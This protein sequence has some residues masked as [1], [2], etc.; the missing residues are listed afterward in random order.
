[1]CRTYGSGVFSS[2][3][4]SLF[5]LR[6]SCP[7]TLTHFSHAG[8]EAHIV[9]QRGA[10]GLMER[11][12]II[13]NKITTL[14]H[15]STLTVDGISVS[16]P[17]DHTYQHVFN[18][19]IYTRLQSKVLPLSVTWYSVPS[20]VS[21]VWVQMDQGLFE[22]MTGLC[23][24]Q[25]SSETMQQ[26]ISSSVFSD[27]QCLTQDTTTPQSISNVC[28]D[29]LSHAYECLGTKYK[30]FL[31][32]CSKNFNGPWHQEANCSFFREVSNLC[33]SSSTF[34]TLWRSKS[35][36]APPVCPGDLH[37]VEMGSAFPPTCSNPKNSSTE[38]TSTCLPPGGMVL[39]DR[40]GGYK[41]ITVD[42]CPCVHAKMTYAPGQQRKTNTCVKTKWIC[43]A[44]TC[45]A[46][47]IIEGQF[48]T[49]FDGKH[50]SLMDRCTY[51]A[52][53]GQNWTL[54]IQYSTHSVSIEKVYLNIDQEKYTFSAN[55]AQLNNIEIGD[56]SHTESTTIIWQS[57][58][59]VQVQTSFGLKMQVQ[60]SPEVQI[61][62]N[63]PPSEETKGLCGVFNNDTNDD[64]TTFSGIIE[65]SVQLF[66]LSWSMGTCST[67]TGCISTDNEMFAEQKCDQLMDPEGLF[68]ACHDYVPVLS[69][70]EACVKRTCQCAGTLQD[71]LCVSFG[72]YAKACAAQGITIADWRTETNCI[73]SCMGNLKF[74]YSALAC[75]HTCRSLSGP[76][77]F[78]EVQDEPVEGCGCP[79]GTHLSFQGTCIPRT[80]CSCYH[81]AGITPPGQVLIG[82]RM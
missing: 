76:G 77:P 40:D 61:Y 35:K 55:S 5:H 64:F 58:M 39:N 70:V 14:V 37:F 80:L 10:R 79:S 68:A 6:S 2:F 12:E 62:L 60:V 9:I 31:D 82:G 45:P 26:L 32:L 30:T 52:A 47:C 66:A 17:Y 29:V 46:Q 49:T 73:P 33:A 28:R 20:G 27:G 43:S 3:N 4:Q 21:S 57:S 24:H 19:G 78:C 41:S 44:N 7:V 11:V 38:L 65:S 16:L 53:R 23:G 1:V 22:G 18:Y 36:C 56:L 75:N 15:N 8:A 50:F 71:C 72:N 54:N 69:Y 59:F 63:L 74:S 48:I 25:N 13:V 81:P 34:R 51:V 42:K 67:I